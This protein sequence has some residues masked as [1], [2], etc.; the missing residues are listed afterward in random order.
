MLND[1]KIGPK[2][3]GG[4]TLGA[5]ITFGMGLMGIYTLNLIQSGQDRLFHEGIEGLE[6]I[7]PR[8]TSHFNETAFVS[9]T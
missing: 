7:W 5:L 1:L 8:P 6:P 2:L 3:I 4:F 9:G